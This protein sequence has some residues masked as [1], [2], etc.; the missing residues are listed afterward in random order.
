M[1]V[2]SKIQNFGLNDLNYHILEFSAKIKRG[3][4]K[5][6][7]ILFKIIYLITKN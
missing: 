4:G 7:R 6:W 5:N 2:L 3:I 1:A